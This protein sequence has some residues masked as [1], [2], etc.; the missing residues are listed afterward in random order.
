LIQVV[1]SLFCAS[2][3]EMKKAREVMCFNWLISQVHQPVEVMEADWLRHQHLR[4]FCHFPD[5]MAQV[6]KVDFR[7][8]DPVRSP[9]FYPHFL[10]PTPTIGGFLH[11]EAHLQVPESHPGTSIQSSMRIIN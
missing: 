7:Q 2:S 3:S 8:Q 11:W 4:N 6:K 1:C 5:L 9:A 10:A